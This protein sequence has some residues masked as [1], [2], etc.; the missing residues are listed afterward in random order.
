MYLVMQRVD[1]D[2]DDE[3]G[4]T[5]LH[6]S[7]HYEGW[8]FVPVLGYPPSDVNYEAFIAPRGWQCVCVNDPD[9]VR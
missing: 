3:F 9:V 2:F 5:L 1:I 6:W 8:Q 4:M 7:G